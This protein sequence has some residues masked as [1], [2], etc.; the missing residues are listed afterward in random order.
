[1]AAQAEMAPAF[2]TSDGATIAREAELYLAAVD[3]F[4]AVCVGRVGM[5]ANGCPSREAPGPRWLSESDEVGEL[6]DP[7]DLPDPESVCPF[8]GAS[9]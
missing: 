6:V 9:C 4:R 1:M 8:E 3:T 2:L 7:D 5:L